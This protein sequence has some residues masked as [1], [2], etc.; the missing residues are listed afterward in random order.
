MSTQIS[1]LTHDLDV[2]HT[3]EVASQG[4]QTT[5]ARLMILHIEQGTHTSEYQT[6]TRSGA[7]CGTSHCVPFYRMPWPT[8]KYISSSEQYNSPLCKTL[9]TEPP[10]RHILVVG[11]GLSTTYKAGTETLNMLDKTQHEHLCA[12]VMWE[13][14]NHPYTIIC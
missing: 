6:T 14:R 13:N 2:C 10:T 7:F 3:P 9:R 4:G 8:K 5:H 12:H 11:G 1:T